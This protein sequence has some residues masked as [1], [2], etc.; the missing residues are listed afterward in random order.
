MF[1]VLDSAVPV[2][3]WSCS[4]AHN[5]STLFCPNCSKIQPPVGGNYYSVFS[6]EPRLN[7]DLTALE[8]ELHRQRAGTAMESASLKP[9]ALAVPAAL[10]ENR[11]PLIEGLPVLS[12]EDENTKASHNLLTD[13]GEDDSQS[14]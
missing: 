3:C 1:E 4:V 8:E 11:Q 10:L 12:I 6:L 5:E 9:A 13:Q 2:A 14:S 7:V